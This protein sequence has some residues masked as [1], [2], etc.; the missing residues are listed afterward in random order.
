VADHYPAMALDDGRALCLSCHNDTPPNPPSAPSEAPAAHDEASE[1]ACSTCHNPH[2][3]AHGGGEP[4]CFTSGCHTV[5]LMHAAH[6]V[7]PPAGPGF[8]LDETGCNECHA[9]GRTQCADAPLFKNPE[10]PPQYLSETAVCDPCHSAV[11][12]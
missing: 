12:P 2:L 11:S 4:N 6:F 3:P 1:I 7:P 9:D 10:G 5:N 8:S